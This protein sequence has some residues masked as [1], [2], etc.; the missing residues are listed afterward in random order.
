MPSEPKL[1]PN[2]FIH[3]TE[4][5][6]VVHGSSTTLGSKASI[7]VAIIIG[8]SLHLVRMLYEYLPFH[9]QLREGDLGRVQGAVSG[10]IAVVLCWCL[11][12][13]LLDHE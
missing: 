5:T 3:V 2:V 1:P 11:P 6:Y 8:E 9:I 13:Q 12:C 10:F 4:S 7:A